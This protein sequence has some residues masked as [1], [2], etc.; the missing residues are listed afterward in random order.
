MRSP[1]VSRWPKEWHHLVQPSPSPQWATIVTHLPFPRS[2]SQGWAGHPKANSWKC[3]ASHTGDMSFC[4]RCPAQGV[5]P[6]GSSTN[7]AAPEKAGQR[8]RDLAAPGPLT[9]HSWLTGQFRAFVPPSSPKVAHP[10]TTWKE[11]VRTEKASCL[12]L[13]SCCVPVAARGDGL[14]M[15]K[16]FSSI[17]R[18][19]SASNILVSNNPCFT[20]KIT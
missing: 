7:P 4:G 18:L 12:S 20:H 6:S 1:K 2:I 17:L 16:L 3:P 10:G 11:V 15:C 9:P 19:L 14:E 13:N 5:T 8:G